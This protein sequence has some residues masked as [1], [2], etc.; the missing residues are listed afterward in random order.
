[1][2]RTVCSATT[3]RG[4]RG[5][6]IKGRG[7]ERPAVSCECLRIRIAP[8]FLAGGGL[9][10]FALGKRST[11]GQL[12]TIP[13]SDSCGSAKEAADARPSRHQFAPPP[14]QQ[15]KHRQ[16]LPMLFV[17][18]LDFRPIHTSYKGPPSR[19]PVIRTGRLRHRGAGHR[20]AAH[21]RRVRRA[22][23]RAHRRRAGHVENGVVSHANASALQ[24]AITPGEKLDAAARRYIGLLASGS[25]S[26]PGLPASVA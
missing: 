21:P 14:L 17:H 4:S 13:R 11:P 1:M 24:A 22:H 3:R 16:R 26:Q 8:F 9:Q 5:A 10:G 12:A 15:R 7:S 23:Q 20:A 19:F 2:I 18:T 25:E 6:A